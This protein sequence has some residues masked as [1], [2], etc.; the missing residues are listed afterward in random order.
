MTDNEQLNQLP[1]WL[2]SYWRHYVESSHGNGH[3]FLI[4]GSAGIGKRRLVTK[5]SQ[6]VLSGAGNTNTQN[7]DTKVGNPSIADLLVLMP[8]DHF[9]DGNY[10]SSLAARFPR[11]TTS[12]KPGS[13][14][15]VDQVRTLINSMSTT[16][17]TSSHKVIVIDYADRMNHQAANSF[18]KT[19]EEPVSNTIIFI[20]TNHLERIPATI[21]SRCVNIHIQIPSYEVTQKWLACQGMD[22]NQITTALSLTGGSPFAAKNLISNN[23]V[24]VHQQ[25]LQ[26]FEQLLFSS[27]VDLS[28]LEK[29]DKEHGTLLVLKSMQW[30]LINKIKQ[31]VPLQRPIGLHL[32]LKRINKALELLGTSVE[33]RLLLEDLVLSVNHQLQSTD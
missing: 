13:W 2:E 9:E 17:Y 20:V 28:V 24:E 1:P 23:Q 26:Q 22:N 32:A 14:I 7:S 31:S 6:H 16:A 21:K 29:V 12:K 3:A 18:L 5:W 10:L 19:L 4:H 8:E 25:L 30:V 11:K 33:K 27:A 15:T